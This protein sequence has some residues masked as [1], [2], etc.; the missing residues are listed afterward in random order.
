MSIEIKNINKSFD[1]R[2]KNLSVLE[3]INLTINDGDEH[4]IPT[5][6]FSGD[7]NI[8]SITIKGNITKIPSKKTKAVSQYSKTGEYITSF[9]N[10]T[11]AEKITKIDR[12]SIGRC[13]RN[14]LKT[15][16]GYIWKFKTDKKELLQ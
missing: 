13:C 3:D 7:N 15:A 8:E 12:S 10:A 14:E 9:K 5:Q 1:G 11:E 6:L 2:G 4:H 16:G